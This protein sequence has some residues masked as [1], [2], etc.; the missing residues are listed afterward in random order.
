MTMALVRLEHDQQDG[1]RVLTLADPDRRNALSVQ[2]QRELG[3]AIDA[4]AGDATARVLVVAG[5]GPAFCAG[6]DLPAMFADVQRPVGEIRER[7]LSA[8]DSF[9]RIRRLAV[10][11]IAAVAG[12]AVGAG[13][14]L[15]LS[16]D[17]RIAGPR[18]SFGATFTRLGLHPG[19][20]CTHYLVRGLGAQRAL[21]M[22]LDGGSLDAGAALDAGLVLEVTDDPLAAALAMA[23]RYARMD[24][25]LVR[26]IK[27]SVAI[28]AAGSFDESVEFESW[29]QAA[30]ATS[31]QLAEAVARFSRPA[32]RPLPD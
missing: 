2:L 22:L 21:A 20:G 19:G 23:G 10:P 30:S 8:Y 29:A 11:T 32:G 16:C 12:P 4:V 13:M 1:V 6:A 17:L 27:R 14:N 28:A 31:P 25:R 3:A 7:L 24:Q 5:A 15:A 26:D 18:A 9:L